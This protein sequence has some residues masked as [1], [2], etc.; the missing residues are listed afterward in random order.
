MNYFEDYANRWAKSEKKYLETLLEVVKSI[1]CLLKSC[2][3]RLRSQKKT[4]Y[5]SVFNIAEVR[6]NL[7]RLHDQYLL[8]TVDKATT[9]SILIRHIMLIALI[10]KELGFNS[11]HGNTTYTHSSV[12]QQGILHN[13]RSISD[14]FNIPN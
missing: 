7:D 8:V 12:Y 9:L 4:I 1:I 14:I 13:H 10:V 6:K 2:F 3:K 11:T 5:P